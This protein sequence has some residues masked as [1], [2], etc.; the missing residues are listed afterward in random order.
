MRKT[1]Y[2]N[3]R[4]LAKKWKQLGTYREISIYALLIYSD[5]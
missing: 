4:L 5:T 1:N 3:K 2:F